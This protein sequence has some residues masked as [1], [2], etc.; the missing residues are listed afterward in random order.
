MDEYDFIIVGAGSAGSVLANRLSE[1]GRFR[2]LVLEAGGPDRSLWIQM[3]IGY[4]RCYFDESVNWRYF[5]EPE[6][7]LNG[8]RIYWPRGK[9]LGGSSSINA[10]VYARGRTRDFDDWAD[11][12]A[13]GWSWK[14]VE[15]V[16]RR[17]ECWSKGGDERRGDS[18][19]LPVED[20]SGR[21]HELC[22]VYFN[23]AAQ[24]GYDRIEDH[25]A[26]QSLGVF[27]YQLTTFR[28][29]RASASRSFLWP[30]LKRS[31]LRLMLRAHA[32]K[33]L[34][35]GRKAVGISYFR[36]NKVF[37]ARARREVLVCGG[38]V[39]SPQLLQLSGIGPGGLLSKF[40]IAALVESPN[41]GRNLQDHLGV[42]FHFRTNVPTLNQVL[43]PW[44]G[45]LKVGMRYFA[46][47]QGPLALSVNQ[48]GG[49]VRSGGK[50]GEPNLQLY[51]SPVSYARSSEI[52]RKMMSPDRFPGML[53]G[54]SNCRPASTGTVDIASADPFEHPLIRPNYLAADKDVDDMI[55]GMR[56]M[57]RFST[58]PAFREIVEREIS[59]GSDIKTDD[60]LLRFVRGAAWTIFHPCCTCRMGGDV[61]NSVVDANLK[62]HGT[63]GLRIAD[64]SVFP[65]ITSGNTNASA[66]M[67][68][69]KASELVL[70]GQP[71]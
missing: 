5:T 21:I 1:S 61:S 28:G 30:V 55:A 67:V 36:G 38:A 62:V 56:L 44:F 71:S 40:G 13:A 59:P 68:G 48:A 7:E 17:I 26:E 18:G 23:A 9:V 10:M 65:N 52:K 29:R 11:A 45:R 35:E 51:F 46:S 4:G 25:N 53:V 12:G 3:P 42:D 43:R 57:R 20:V 70:K 54:F 2:V 31:N 63:E 49:F 32:A 24:L 19:P 58:T 27:D 8:R 16:F 69:E 37:E 41:V 34:F 50:G 22:R 39:N 33:I 66:I 14:D 15:P 64:A 47:R 60:E 6:P